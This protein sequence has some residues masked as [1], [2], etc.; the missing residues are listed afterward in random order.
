M[1]LNLKLGQHHGN[2]NRVQ[3][4]YKSTASGKVGLMTPTSQMHLESE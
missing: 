1:R 3:S 2:N 4:A